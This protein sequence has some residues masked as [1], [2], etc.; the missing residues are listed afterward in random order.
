VEL[1]SINV[2][3]DSLQPAQLFVKLYKVTYPVGRDSSGAISQA[4]AVE[5]TPTTVF[6][7]RKGVVVGR[8]EGGMDGAE[9]SRRIETLLK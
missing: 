7:D 3:W 4:Y 5:A 2:P 1:L 8:T 9:L 6:I